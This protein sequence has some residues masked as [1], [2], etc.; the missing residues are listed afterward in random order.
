MATMLKG[1]NKKITER[2]PS[3]G[4]NFFHYSLMNYYSIELIEVG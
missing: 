4:D 2:L 3:S 1:L